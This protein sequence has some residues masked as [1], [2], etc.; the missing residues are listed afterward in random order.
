MMSKRQILETLAA[1]PIIGVIVDLAM[2]FVAAIG[3]TIRTPSDKVPFVDATDAL[4]GALKAFSAGLLLYAVIGG[5]V[6][7][8]V[9]P[10]SRAAALQGML[11]APSDMEQRVMLFV[12]YA[13]FAF[14]MYYLLSALKWQILSPLAAMVLSFHAAAL[15][16]PLRGLGE[17]LVSIVTSGIWWSFEETGDTRDLEMLPTMMLLV[18][19]IF[20]VPALMI[21][22]Q[23]F[24]VWMG[25][26]Y[27]VRVLVM[28]PVLLAAGLASAFGAGWFLRMSA[29]VPE[30]VI[31]A[32]SLLS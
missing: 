7:L 5:L 19:A 32:L 23:F 15:L 3:E 24:L 4:P 10:P 25:R 20:I 1:L 30:K 22:H 28:L 9:E 18:Q 2:T 21:A 17:A 6:N 31:S 13:G 12:L 11:D 16:L 27:A 8:F 29:Q 14:V 26:A